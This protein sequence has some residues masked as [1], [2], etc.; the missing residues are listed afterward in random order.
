MKETKLIDWNVKILTVSE[1]SFQ[2]KQFEMD[3]EFV[4]TGKAFGK[5]IAK[6]YCKES[7]SS[8]KTRV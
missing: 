8:F 5:R 7:S 4:G 1:T 6:A 2:V 3:G